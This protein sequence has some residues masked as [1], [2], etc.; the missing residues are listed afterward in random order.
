MAQYRCM[1]LGSTRNVA[2]SFANVLDD[3]ELLTGTPTITATGLTISGEVV[4][5]AILTIDGASVPIGEAVQC[6]VTGGAAGVTYEMDI[7]VST[8]AATAQVLNDSVFIQ[9]E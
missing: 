9:V 8:D 3:G 1:K 7:T 4:S 2:V 5:T 6:S